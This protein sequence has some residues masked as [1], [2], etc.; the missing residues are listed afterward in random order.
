MSVDSELPLY[1]SEVFTAL[2]VIYMLV[3]SSFAG[4]SEE[5]IKNSEN[6]KN[7][8][9]TNQE[10]EAIAS[11][12]M[13]EFNKAIPSSINRE[14]FYSDEGTGECRET[15]FFGD[16][17]TNDMQPSQ[18]QDNLSSGTIEEDDEEEEKSRDEEYDGGFSIPLMDPKLRS[19]QT[20]LNAR[21]EACQNNS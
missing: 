15:M 12:K 9:L 17:F 1:C 19:Q 20:M 3:N 10:E 8:P 21:F 14:S 5:N 13:M 4:N 18:D 2:L 16:N 11:H 7:K 6:D